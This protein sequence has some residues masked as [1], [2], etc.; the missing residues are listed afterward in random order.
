MTILHVCLIVGAGIVAAVQIGKV[1]IAIPVLQPALALS[2]IEASALLSLFALFGATL[3]IPTGLTVPRLGSR[4]ALV[5]GLGLLAV[6][7]LIGAFSPSFAVLLFSRVVEGFGF[8]VI[9]TAAPV[10]LGHAVEPRSRAPVLAVWGIYMPVGMGLMT[11]AGMA[12]DL[13][14]W[15]GLWL[16]NAALA[17]AWCIAVALLLPSSLGRTND[18]AELPSISA[19][20]RGVL[21]DRRPLLVALSFFLYG[22]LYFCVVGFL[23]LFLI[24]ELEA[25]IGWIAPMTAAVIFANA[26]GNL[27]SGILLRRAWRFHAIIVRA[28]VLAALF[29]SAGFV[30][31]N[32]ALAVALMVAG[33]GVAGTI[34]AATMASAAYLTADVRQVGVLIGMFMQGSTLGQFAGP[35]VF[36]LVVERFGWGAAPAV[37]LAI[38]CAGALASGAAGRLMEG[39]GR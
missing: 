39:P 16:G 8:I 11:V 36:A 19:T 33:I 22:C 9:A 15:R 28:F 13:A 2:L 31:P 26:G 12:L 25:S 3:G 18:G 10:L 34:P 7:S 5:G 32:Q 24:A 37:I 35:P 29:V 20:L 27:T 38:G 17:G 30:M 14:D 21:G 6:G 1:V 23:P 4:R